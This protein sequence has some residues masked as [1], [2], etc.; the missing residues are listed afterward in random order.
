V[1]IQQLKPKYLSNI[2]FDQCQF[3]NNVAAYAATGVQEQKG[4]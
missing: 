4:E 1:F 2:T 3:V